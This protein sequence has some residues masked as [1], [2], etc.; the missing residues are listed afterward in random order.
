MPVLQRK[1]ITKLEFLANHAHFDSVQACSVPHRT[2]LCWDKSHDPCGKSSWN[3]ILSLQ[4]LP[5]GKLFHF[6]ITEKRSNPL[7]ANLH[8]F[9]SCM[10]NH[11]NIHFS[12]PVAYIHA[13]I[14]KTSPHFPLTNG[15]QNCGC[16]H[17]TGKNIPNLT[18]ISVWHPAACTSTF[19][20]QVIQ[21]TSW[22]PFQPPFH[23]SLPP[24]P[25]TITYFL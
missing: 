19:L 6:L 7:V 23:H 3:Q 10:T 4:S 2:Y 11:F 24:T 20:H 12:L 16:A 14:T 22:T 17:N 25:I 5:S 18:F 8:P 21:N 15:Q 1:T 9:C 13:G